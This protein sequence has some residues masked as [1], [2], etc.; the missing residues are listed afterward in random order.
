MCEKKTEREG[1][2]Q[3]E[4]M[5]KNKDRVR[6]KTSRETE[7]TFLIEIRKENIEYSTRIQKN[8]E[9]NHQEGV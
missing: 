5:R 7:G 2:H 9:R 3:N 8:K 4:R 1:K 6:R